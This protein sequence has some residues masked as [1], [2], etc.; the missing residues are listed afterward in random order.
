M[1]MSKLEFLLNEIDPTYEDL[2]KKLEVSLL[3]HILISIFT[4]F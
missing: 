1:H 2:L 4:F 3:F